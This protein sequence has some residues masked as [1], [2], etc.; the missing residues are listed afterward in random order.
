M[1]FVISISRPGKP[2]NLREGHGKSWK[3]MEKTICL[4]KNYRQVKNRLQY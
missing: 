4:A 2:W 1:E 3:V